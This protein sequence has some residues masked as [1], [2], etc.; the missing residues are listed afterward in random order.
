MTN[1]NEQSTLRVTPRDKMN[2]AVGKKDGIQ[3]AINFLREKQIKEMYENRS[4]DL[5]GMRQRAATIQLLDHL[6]LDLHRVSSKI[7]LYSNDMAGKGGK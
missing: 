6:M 4:N 7:T 5:E 1:D 3:T 2:Y